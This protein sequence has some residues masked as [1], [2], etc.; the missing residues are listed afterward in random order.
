MKEFK[1][2][3]S[4]AG[5]IMTNPR[6]KSETLSKTTQTY[7]QDWVK[8]QLYNRRK[9]FT[10]KY[11]DKGIIVEDNSIDTYAEFKGIPMLLKNEKY[12][13]DDFFTGTPDIVLPKLVVDIKSS[14]NA[15]TFPLFETEVESNYFLQAQIY[16]HLTGVHKFELAYILSDTPQLQIEREAFW[17]CQ[18]TGYEYSEAILSEFKA[19]MTYTDVSVNLRIKTYQIEYD[20]AKIV[21]LIERVKLC[22]QYITELLI[23]NN[24]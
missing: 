19:K 1:I 15:F 18:R 13:E 6:S 5:Q 17:H 22:R 3:A 16:M 8:E 9:E 21:E 23:S 11:T 24:L 14:W 12:Y 2:R 4:G 20:E 10:S 7:C